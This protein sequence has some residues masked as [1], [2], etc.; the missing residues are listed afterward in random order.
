LTFSPPAA[1][2]L[3]SLA[4]A[5]PAGPDSLERWVAILSG[6]ATIVIAAALIAIFLAII[7]LA[8]N[9]RRAQRRVGKLIDALQD[10]ARPVMLHAQSVADNVDFVSTAVRSDVERL[11]RTIDS[12]QSRLERA[13]DVAEDRIS[14]FNS[15]LEVV[16]DEAE[17]LFIDTAS[18]VRGVRAGARKLREPSPELAWEDDDQQAE[19]P[20][21]PRRHL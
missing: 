14:R 5:R 20:E 4:Q 21:R 13:A 8:L 10:Q 17:S 19:Q 6:I 12:A 15:L 9:A 7:P 18:T 1:L 3:L 11:R 16:Q 2:A